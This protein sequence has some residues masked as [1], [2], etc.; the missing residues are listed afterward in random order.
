MIHGT[1][2]LGR[3]CTLQSSNLASPF[4][5]AASMCCVWAQL[6]CRKKTQSPVQHEAE[7]KARGVVMF[8]DAI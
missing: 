2:A 6:Q 8:R 3:K 7:S 1:I 4:S 5:F